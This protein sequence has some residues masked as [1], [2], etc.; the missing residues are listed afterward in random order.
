[1]SGFDY[2]EVNRLWRRRDTIGGHLF[3]TTY[4]YDDWD[5]L[6]HMG[7]P[8]SHSVDYDYDRE[9]RVTRVMRDPSATLVAN[10]TAYHPW[11]AVR[12][13][14]YGNGIVEQFA[15]DGRDRLQ[16]ASGGPLDL[17]YTYDYVGNVK[18]FTDERTGYT[19]QIN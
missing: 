9:N 18:S 11:G 4:G 5:N 1:A 14:T 15:A 17:T 13:L 7:S 12:T 19:Q 10:V 2:D 16:H 6:K 3:E 8:S